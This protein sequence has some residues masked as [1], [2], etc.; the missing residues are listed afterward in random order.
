MYIFVYIHT[1]IWHH[2]SVTTESRYREFSYDGACPL[3]FE[4]NND[5]GVEMLVQSSTLYFFFEILQN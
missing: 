2:A 5:N 1:C 3:V 4:F